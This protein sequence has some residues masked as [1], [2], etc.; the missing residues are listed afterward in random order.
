MKITL[1]AILCSSS[2][3]LTSLA[4]PP[5]TTDYTKELSTPAAEEPYDLTHR[6][7]LFAE[8]KALFFFT[9]QQEVSYYLQH[10]VAGGVRFTF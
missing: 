9:D 3:T 1:A 6:I 10:L 2:L 5:Q 4:G 7:S 8:Y